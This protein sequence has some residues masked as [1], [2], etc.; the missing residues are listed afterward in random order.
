MQMRKNRDYEPKQEEIEHV[1]AVM[2]LM[3]AVTGDERYKKMFDGMDEK[4]GKKT[5]TC[6]ALDKAEVRGRIKILCE[7]VE[8]GVITRAEGAR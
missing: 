4:G 8:E 3:A 2:E 1:E 6:L 5:M 7:L